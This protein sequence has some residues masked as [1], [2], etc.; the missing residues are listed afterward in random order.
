MG[1]RADFYI[2]DKDN[3]KKEDWIASI[4]WDGYL[5]GIDSEVINS[6]SKPDFLIALYNFL[7]NRDDV[8]RAEHGWPWPWKNSQ[9]T[10]CS[11]VFDINDNKLYAS[12]WGKFWFEAS[13]GEPEENDERYN[14]NSVIYYPDFTTENLA[15]DSAKS[16]I[17][18]IKGK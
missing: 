12:M 2:G 15:L 18:I 13:L 7:A 5:E 6:K 1:T 17:L 9:T 8:T 11:Y 3:L 10:D 16:G 14:S 4:A